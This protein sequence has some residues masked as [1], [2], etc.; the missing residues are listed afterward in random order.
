MSPPTASSKNTS[1]LSFANLR[2]TATWSQS[3]AVKVL[4]IRPPVVDALNKRMSPVS[5]YF[6]NYFSVMLSNLHG[7]L[8]PSADKFR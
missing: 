8:I 5:A 1:S 7:A 4:V 3:E 2:T 6:K